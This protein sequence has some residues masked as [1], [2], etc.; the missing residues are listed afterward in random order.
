MWIISLLL[1]ILKNIFVYIMI[2]HLYLPWSVQIFS[3]IL[4]MQEFVI[5]IWHVI[6]GAT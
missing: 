4:C 3:W 6:V 5:G 2:V 1:L